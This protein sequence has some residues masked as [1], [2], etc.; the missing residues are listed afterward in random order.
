MDQAGAEG[1]A[2]A[3]K[4]CANELRSSE[5]DSTFVPAR[6]ELLWSL[7]YR[8]RALPFKALGLPHKKLRSPVENIFRSRL[9]DAGRS[10]RWKSLSTM[11]RKVTWFKILAVFEAEKELPCLML[12]VIVNRSGESSQLT[13]VTS[14]FKQPGHMKT[15]FWRICA[16]VF[17][18]WCR[19]GES[20]LQGPK[21]GEFC[22]TPHTCNSL[23]FRSF[24]DLHL[25]APQ[26]WCSSE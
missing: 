19:E 10:C 7:A 16:T 25:T 17:G 15:R 3:F 12:G 8:C 20:N 26:D 2:L 5:A 9:A 14:R 13:D 4:A 24:C 11:P 6:M 22:V 21:P 1:W 18:S 23:R